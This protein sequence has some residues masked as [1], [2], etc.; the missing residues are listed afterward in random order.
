MAVAKTGV[1]LYDLRKF[2]SAGHG[3]VHMGDFAYHP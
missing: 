2:V 1:F 3:Q